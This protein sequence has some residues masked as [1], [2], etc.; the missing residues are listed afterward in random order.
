MTKTKSQMLDARNQFAI[1][2]RTSLPPLGF[3]LA[4]VLA[5]EIWLVQSVPFFFLGCFAGASYALLNLWL[6]FSMLAPFFFHREKAIYV[7]YGLLISL[8]V[9]ALLMF[10]ATLVGQTWAMGFAFGVASPAI[11]GTLYSLQSMA[12]TSKT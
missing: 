12:T 2:L 10:A 9:G 1:M 4:L 3:L 11:V 5:C 7:L 8:G 6:L